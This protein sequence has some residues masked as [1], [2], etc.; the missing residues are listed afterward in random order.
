MSSLAKN[1]AVELGVSLTGG[2]ARGSYQA[3]VLL[4]L[5]EYCKEMGFVGEKSPIQYLTG[6]SAGSINAAFMAAGIH[7]LQSTAQKLVKLWSDI[8]PELVYKTDALSL[9][10]NSVRWISDLTMGAMMKKKLARSLLDT[11]PLF[12]LLNDNIQFDLIAE[13]LRAGLFKGLACSAYSYTGNQTLTFLQTKEEC[14]WKRHRRYSKN[15]EINATHVAASCAIPILFPSIKLGDEYFADGSFRN[16][17]PISPIIHMGA[18]KI[19]VIGVRARDEFSEKDYHSEPGVA[20]IAGVILNALF[21]DTLDIDLERIKHINDLIKATQ[22]KIETDRSDYEALDYRVIRPSRDISRIAAQK[23]KNFPRLINF[24]LGGLGAVEES[25]ELASY[26]L[27]VPE[28]TNDLIELGY[29]DFKEQ[30]DYL[31]PWFEKS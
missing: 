26:L 14:G 28:F 1:S 4:G 27:F 6:V 19:L 13:H 20:K 10:K 11:S 25:A 31:R 2:G 17:T 23:A 29:N 24:L 5:S 15:V 16:T 22:S 12:D 3:G 30:K 9:G 8:Q 21:F 18:K 7:D